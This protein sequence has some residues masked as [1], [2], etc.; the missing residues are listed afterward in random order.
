MPF[1]FEQ[2]AIPGLVLVRPRSFEDPRGAFRELYKYSDFAAAGISETFMQDNW[3]R[4][5][6]GVL[7]GLHFQRPPR[8]QAKLVW[9]IQGEIYDV[10][11]DI[12]RGSETYGEWLGVTLSSDESSLLYVPAGFAHGYCVLSDGVEVHYK[13]TAE[14]APE[15]EG[16]LAW[17]DPDLAIAWPV[18][19]PL[20]SEKD[21][22]WPRLR[23]LEPVPA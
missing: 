19:E 13:L 17:D 10:V 11:V 12:R 9:A 15:F 7:R 16:G 3:S 14:F 2:L 4:S 18:D 8:A 6:K 22:T 23:E 21:R 5:A 20:L 1:T